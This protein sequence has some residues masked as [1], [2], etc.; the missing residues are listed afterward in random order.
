MK[1]SLE[2]IR[3]LIAAL[4]GSGLDELYLKDSDTEISLRRGRQTPAPARSVELPASGTLPPPAAAAEAA[5]GDEGSEKEQQPD[6]TAGE[7]ITVR[8]VTAGVFYRAARP[9]EAP[10]TEVGSHVNKGDTIAM[11]EAMKMISEIT[12]PV[13]GIV[14]K[15][16]V[17]D[18]AYAGYDDGLMVIAED[19]NV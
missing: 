4:D 15:I 2:D 6:G 11:M 12:S 17:K 13:S 19:G 10:F 18:G 1:L 7:E 8:A 14:K 16:L 5:R 3:A 9:G